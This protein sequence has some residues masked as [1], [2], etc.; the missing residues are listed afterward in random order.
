MG[1]NA[2]AC[3]GTGVRIRMGVTLIV[4]K[5]P[6]LCNNQE[7]AGWD[8]SPKVLSTPVAW[9]PLYRVREAGEMLTRL[10]WV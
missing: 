7:P 1:S 9:Q 10:A 8:V 2:K 6:S 4:R 5:D 3:M